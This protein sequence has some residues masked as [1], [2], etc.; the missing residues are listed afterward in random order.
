MT[1]SL[2]LNLTQHN[3]LNHYKQNLKT[4]SCNVIANKLAQTYITMVTK[5]KQRLE[6][7]RL[8]GQNCSTQQ[9]YARQLKIQTAEKRKDVGKMWKT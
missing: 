1:P 7:V 4:K 5:S 9:D 2:Q 8:H 3:G 6:H